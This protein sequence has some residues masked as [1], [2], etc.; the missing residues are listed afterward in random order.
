MNKLQGPNGTRFEWT[1]GDKLVRLLPSAGV[2]SPSDR[3]W[4]VAHIADLR[5]FVRE[6]EALE[7]PG[8]GMRTAEIDDARERLKATEPKPKGDSQ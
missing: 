1:D 2:M 5:A 3:R 8:P 7:K 4:V 6:L